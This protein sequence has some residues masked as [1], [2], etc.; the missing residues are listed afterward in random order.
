[1]GR[2][3]VRSG[4]SV[5]ELVLVFA[6]VGILAFLG[7]SFLRQSLGGELAANK[8]EKT[9]VEAVPAAPEVRTS[10]DLD[11]VSAT[12]DEMKFDDNA[13]AKELSSEL[14]TF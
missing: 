6:V 12:L 1:M 8:N 2:R 3:S 14:A 4:F 5:V 9:S 7:Y 13:E 11:T 10:S